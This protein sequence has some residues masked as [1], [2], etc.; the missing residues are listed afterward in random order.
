VDKNPGAVLGIVLGVAGKAKRDKVTIIASPGIWDLGAWLE[1]LIAESTG[2]E[3]KA[4]IPV[5]REPLG[6]PEVYG[7]D[8]V[9]AYF[10]AGV[11]AGSQPGQGRGG[12]GESRAPRDTNLRG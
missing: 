4:L 2:K 5:D 7:D 11:S 10:A 12:A 1:Q 9:F 3:G 6:S 8:R